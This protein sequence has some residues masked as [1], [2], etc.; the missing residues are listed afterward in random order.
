M[1]KIVAALVIVIIAVIVILFISNKRLPNIVA[2]SL[3]QITQVS[4]KIGA[5]G[6][7]PNSIKVDTLEFGNPPGSILS[8]S[9]IAK[10]MLL[11]A[12]LA[13][14]VSNNVVIDTITLDDIYLGLE[15]DSQFGSRGNWTTIM[16]NINS[17]IDSNA[18]QGT[19]LIKKLILRNISPELVYRQGNTRPKK[20]RTIPYLEF[21]NVSS[22]AGIQ[23]QQIANLVLEHMLLSVFDVENLGNMLE[24]VSKF[25]FD[26]IQK[27]L[28]PVKGIFGH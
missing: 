11:E 23:S 8:N 7:A 9:F 10:T 12:P 17:S 3:S 20:L 27:P 1:K 16:G 21:N 13:N 15:F 25:G 26:T 19:V 6:I 5:I 18:S 2:N 22:T 14:Y 28:A 4:V 24:G